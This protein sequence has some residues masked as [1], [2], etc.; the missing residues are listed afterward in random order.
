MVTWILAPALGSAKGWSA[1]QAH[2]SAV[3]GLLDD[4]SPEQPPQ[5]AALGLTISDAPYP[6]VLQP[7]GKPPET[8]P[9]RG[10]GNIAAQDNERVKRSTVLVRE[11]RMRPG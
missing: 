4:F 6:S 8:P 5:F 10:S 11:R 3:L 7:I 1:R 9:P 2:G